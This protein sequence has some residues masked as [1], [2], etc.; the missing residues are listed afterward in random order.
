MKHDTKYDDI[1]L[2]K[3]YS[4]PFNPNHNNNS[5]VI[6]SSGRGK[7]TSIVEAQLL[8][9]FHNSIVFTFSKR[10]RMTGY[11]KLLSSRG[12]NIEYIDFVNTVKGV[13]AEFL[14]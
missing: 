12:Y 4:K 1:I 10:K 9:S 3:N 8:H 2:S 14:E 13:T 6:A 7:T 5:L 11:V